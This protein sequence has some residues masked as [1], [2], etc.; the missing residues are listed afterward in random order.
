MYIAG[1]IVFAGNTVKTTKHTSEKELTFI[2]YLYIVILTVIFI[3]F[4]IQ[5]VVLKKSY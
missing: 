5:T 2:S 1:S 3:L 4:F